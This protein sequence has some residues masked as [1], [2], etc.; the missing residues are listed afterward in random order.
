M[1]HT[2]VKTVGIT[3]GIAWGLMALPLYFFAD[4]MMI[5]GAIGGCALSAVCF[6]AGFYAVCRSFDASF[7]TLMMTVFG[8]MLIRLLFIGTI[9]LLIV[10]VTS[11]HVLSFL[12][13][14]FGF[15]VLYMVIELYLVKNRLQRS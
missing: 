10:S 3:T 9:V 7:N 6:T 4:S 14:L 11:L 8:G 12:A 15:Y 13:S 5:W 2:F 1:Y